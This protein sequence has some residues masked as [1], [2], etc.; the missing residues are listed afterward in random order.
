[1]VVDSAP[2]GMASVTP[3]AVTLPPLGPIE[4]VTPAS[5][6]RCSETAPPPHAST[7]AHASLSEHVAI[8]A[9]L[10]QPTQ[11]FTGRGA[12]PG[13]P[14]GSA[15]ASFRTRDTDSTFRQFALV[16][17][18]PTFAFSR[19]SNTPS[20]AFGNMVLDLNDQSYGGGAQLAAFTRDNQAAI[21]ASNYILPI[22]FLDTYPDTTEIFSVDPS[23][24]AEVGHAFDLN[25]CGGCH[26]HET[27][28]NVFQV[29]SRA[30]GAESALS[31]FLTGRARFY[32]G[33]GLPLGHFNELERRAAFLRDLVCP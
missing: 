25:T 11:A 15:L 32:L 8:L 1:M 33:T 2:D 18:Q 16:D 3:L 23:L 29:S 6:A 30:L 14:N 28:A 19:V 12:L 21:L 7:A 13:A 4:P 10:Q 26:F 17:Q 27:P 31:P 9:G 22:Q 24:S 5:S 20:F